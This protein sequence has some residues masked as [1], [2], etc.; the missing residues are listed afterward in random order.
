[1]DQFSQ[2]RAVGL[3]E[4]QHPWRTGTNQDSVHLN[5]A[6]VNRPVLI[7]P[8]PYNHIYLCLIMIREQDVLSFSG[9]Q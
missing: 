2:L 3:D 4:Q 6:E 1:M 7:P 9:I 5:L 8:S